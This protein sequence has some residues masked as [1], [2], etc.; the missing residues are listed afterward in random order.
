MGLSYQNMKLLFVDLEHKGTTAEGD[1]II[2]VSSVIG[3]EGSIQL[4][5]LSEEGWKFGLGRGDCDGN[6][7][8]GL[9][10][11]LLLENELN[12]NSNDPPPSGYVWRWKES[13]DVEGCRFG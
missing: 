1:A 8:D 13:D 7:M 5:L 11:A 12:Q 9:D 4:S 3:N 10:A 2:G 6:Y